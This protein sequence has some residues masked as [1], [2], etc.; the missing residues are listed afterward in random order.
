M[1]NWSLKTVPLTELKNYEKNPRILSERHQRLLSDSI[2]K[3]GLAEK[4]IVNTDYTLIGGHQRVSAMALKGAQEIQVWYPHRTLDEK[5]LE[6][7]NILLNKVSGDFDY[8]MLG[9][10]FDTGDLLSWGFD[11]EELGL[12]KAEKPKPQPK[13]VI[14]LEFSSKD[15]MLEHLQLCE[16]IAQTSS[17]KLKVRG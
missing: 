6:E 13:P 7:F 16:E 15:S 3:F 9:N 17:A 4:P 12:G 1:I 8:D 11:E 10:I 2:D 5:D 14:S